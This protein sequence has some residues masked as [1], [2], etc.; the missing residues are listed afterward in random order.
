MKPWPRLPSDPRLYYFAVPNEIFRNGI[1]AC[2][3]SIL[4]Y[5]FCRQMK[6]LPP[7]N[8]M[9]V[10]MNLSVSRNTIKNMCASLRTA[11]W[12]LCSA[13]K[14][15]CAVPFLCAIRS[16]SQ[17]S[18]SFASVISFLCRILFSVSDCPSERLRSMAIFCTERIGRAMN[19]G[20]A[21]VPSVPR[22]ACLATR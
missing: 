4:A 20:P 12:F 21:T 22:C 16:C 8:L 1:T 18:S 17:S 13:I 2:E 15:S 14:D 5:L 11:V 6:K 19:A 3:F 10:K 7:T 9:T